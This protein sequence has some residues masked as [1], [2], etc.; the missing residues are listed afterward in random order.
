[1]V[2][3]SLFSRIR[4]PIRGWLAEIE[5]RTL[6]GRGRS[7]RELAPVERQVL[8]RIN[9]ENLSKHAVRRPGSGKVEV[10]VVRQVN[11]RVLVG[12]CRVANGER[13]IVRERVG[14]ADLHFAGEAFLAIGTGVG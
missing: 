2:S 11:H 6:H 9:G 7:E 4:A 12:H 1:M 3:C 8:I 10:H 13:A 5:R 14:D